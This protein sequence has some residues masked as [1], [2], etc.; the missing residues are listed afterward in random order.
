MVK[1]ESPQENV[2]S[3]LPAGPF[4]EWGRKG[5]DYVGVGVG[6]LIVN[7]R[8]EVLLLLRTSPPEADYWSIPGGSV[9]MFETLEDAVI[10]EVKEE[11]NVDATVIRLIGV[12]NHIVE[13]E[14]THW[15][16]PAFLVQITGNQI[17]VNVEVNKHRDLQWFPI[18]DLPRN[19]TLTAS[20]ALEYLFEQEE[21]GNRLT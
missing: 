20:K 12:T 16:A 5:K 8:N 6:A 18:N 3:P 7:E 4:Q 9:E 10:R 14:D 19:I 1:N 17:P 15:V 11:L 2:P 21:K 13:Q